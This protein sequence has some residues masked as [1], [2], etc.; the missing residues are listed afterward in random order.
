MI[1]ELSHYNEG[2]HHSTFPLKIGDIDNATHDPLTKTFEVVTLE[3][4]RVTICL[5]GQGFRVLSVTSLS[6]DGQDD[7]AVK[8]THRQL[9]A[10]SGHIYETIE[11]LLMAMSPAF[12]E[13][14]ANELSRR[15]NSVSWETQRQSRLDASSSEE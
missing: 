11:A 9:E 4:A 10:I 3:H 7:F 6:G 14:F 2:L 12:E 15:L 8:A 1:P 13:F 5:N